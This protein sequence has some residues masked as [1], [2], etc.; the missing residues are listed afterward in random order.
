MEDDASVRRTID[1]VWRIEAARLIGALA[2]RTG[3]LG[4]AEDLAQD[5]LLAALEQW[6]SG[7]VPTNPGGWLT[8]VAQ[9]RWV[10]RV[11]REVTA[12]RTLPELARA[13]V[14]EQDPMAGLQL[15]PH[16]EDDL[17]RLIFT[18][19]HPILAPQARVA[20][21]LKVVSGLSTEAIARAF[22]VPVATMAQRI[23]RAKRVLSAADI[24]F[25]A[26]TGDDLQPRLAS[27]LGVIYL[28]FNEGYTATD[29]S[30]WT[31]PHLC[32]EALRLG[33]IVAAVLPE[34]PETFGL[35]A[36]LEIQ[37]SRMR[38][39]TGPDGEPITL[40]EQNRARWDRTL[41]THG[42][43]QLH[44]SLSLSPHPGPYTVQAA[45]AACHARASATDTTDWAEIARLYAVLAEL[46]PSP[47]IE[48]NR[49]VAVA[50]AE[51]PAAGLAILEPLLGRPE[52]AHYHL[53][54]SVHGDLLHRV[55][56]CD[57]ARAEFR[58]AAAMTA[59]ERERGLLLGRA[60]TC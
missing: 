39:R 38:A 34:Q 7:G 58:R 19:C 24:G 40:A 12:T 31:R 6:P 26:P 32:E 27:V 59:N 20:L 51:D 42:L 15:D 22:L 49:A 44:R 56:R 50:L 29:G 4:I 16:V 2:R 45:I 8:T 1:A 11:R 14:T 60:E 52:L 30:D 9:R 21:S 37:A 48:L 53:L 46:T 41:I 5:A 28:I 13:T 23:V 17:L 36:L 57:E 10:D 33:R 35:V 54:P 47:V 25:E 55:G 18:A 3:D 43:A